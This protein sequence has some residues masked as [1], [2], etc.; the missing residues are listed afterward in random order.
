MLIN[1]FTFY[2]DH[3]ALVYLVNKQHVFGKLTKW[4][5]LF[6]EYDFKIVYKPSRSHLMADAL[7][8]LHNQ[9]EPIV[10]PDET[11]DVHMFTLQPEWLHNV[12]EYLLKGVILE[13]FITSQRQYLAQRAKPFVFQGV[14][15]KFG[16][17]NTFQ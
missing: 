14:L 13:R 7:S 1:M 3:M 11:S 4:L 16:Q 12:Y 6:M 9:T 5:L 8:R 15:Y 2:I 10:I 17:K